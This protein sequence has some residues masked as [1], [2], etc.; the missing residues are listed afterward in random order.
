MKMTTKHCP[1]LLDRKK[2]T[3]VYFIYLFI[4]VKAHVK[5][6]KQMTLQLDRKV[7]DSKTC[8]TLKY[9]NKKTDI[10]KHE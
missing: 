3:N 10:Q 6:I 8:P 2:H 1:P 7:H 4:V 9:K 5:Q